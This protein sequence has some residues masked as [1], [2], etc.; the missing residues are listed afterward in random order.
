MGLLTVIRKQK[1]KDK[2]LR[3]IILGL[4]NSGKSTILNSILD[5]PNTDISPTLGFEIHSLQHKSHNLNFWDIGG[6]ESIR[7]FWFNYFFDKFD[8]IFFVIDLITINSRFNEIYN[9]FIRLLENERF[10]QIKLIII[11]NKM[12]LFD[13]TD[14]ESIKEEVIKKLEL[15]RYL[16]KYEIV[17]V[18][19]KEGK[20]ID[21]L[22]DK[23]I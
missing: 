8:Y 7:T 23:I 10:E 11:L 9:E 20:N 13:N 17:M 21:L 4:D 5:K 14:S 1:L 12:D 18:S 16:V 19:G 3:I 22:L 2:E 6:Q 15:S